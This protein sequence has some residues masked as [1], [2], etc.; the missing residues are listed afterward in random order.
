MRTLLCRILISSTRLICSS[1]QHLLRLADEGRHGVDVVGMGRGRVLVVGRPAQVG[2]G[3][4]RGGRRRG[5]GR[6]GQVRL[7]V[8]GDLGEVLKLK[9][10]PDI[11]IV[12]QQNLISFRI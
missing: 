7:G 9:Y 12:Q 6:R 11:I 5:A 4:D 2:R 10:I 8:L 3:R 1:A